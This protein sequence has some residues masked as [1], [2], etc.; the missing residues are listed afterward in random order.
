MCTQTESEQTPK[1]TNTQSD[2][3]EETVK[4]GRQIHFDANRP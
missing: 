2:S 4:A 1:P 3:Q